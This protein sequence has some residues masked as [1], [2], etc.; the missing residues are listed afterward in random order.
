[1]IDSMIKNSIEMKG[2]EKD[3]DTN[4]IQ[5]MKGV[6]DNGRREMAEK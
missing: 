2:K 6:R 1:M 4:L 5:R 3:K